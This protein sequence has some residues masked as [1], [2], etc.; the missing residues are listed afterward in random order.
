MLKGLNK[1]NGKPNRNIYHCCIQKSGSQW[2]RKIFG[3]PLIQ[4]KTEFTIFT[5]EKDYIFLEENRAELQKA[6]PLNTIVSPL[7][8]SYESFLRIPKPDRYKAF[9]VMRDPRDLVIS[10]YFSVK[11]CHPILNKQQEKERKYLK[12]VTMEE[13]IRHFIEAITTIHVPLYSSLISWLKSKEDSNVIICKYEDLIGRNQLDYFKKIFKHCGLEIYKDDLTT[14]L[15]RYSFEQL[16][17]GR[18]Q[19]REDLKS[20]YRK[21][22]SGDWKNYFTVQHKQLFKDLAGELLIRLQYEKANNW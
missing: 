10:R 2:I 1:S 15:F 8:V 14:L 19:G 12:K 6:F 3:D 4:E 17:E 7:Y 18:K 21:G 9:W 5:P 20:H 16:S 13:G 11:Y 22:I